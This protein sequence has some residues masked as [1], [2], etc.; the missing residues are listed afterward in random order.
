MSSK[1]RRPAASVRKRRYV[2]GPHLR[3]PRAGWYYAYLSKDEPRVALHT[4]NPAEAARIFG[5]LLDGRR[6]RGVGG[7]AEEVPLAEI[8][9]RYLSAP[10]G[11]TARTVRACEERALAFVKWMDQHNVSLASQITAELRDQ[12]VT[13]RM[14][15]AGRKGTGVKRSTVNRDIVVARKMLK[16]AAHAERL[17]CAR[18]APME[19]IQP[20]REPR[21]LPPPIIPSPR[22]VALAIAALERLGDHGGALYLASVLSTGM[23]IDETRNV[24]LG[25]VHANGVQLG[26]VNGA[27]A[28]DEWTVKGFAARNI[29]LAPASVD[30]FTR[31]IAWRNGDAESARAALS[32]TWAGDVCDRAAKAAG[33][34]RFRSH[35]LRRTFATECYR[36]DIPLVTIQLWMGHKDPE[37]TKRYLGH[38]RDDAGAVAP[39][40]AALSIFTAKLG[41]VVPMRRAKAT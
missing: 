1:D 6:P 13:H 3:A 34:A 37:T 29:P 40:P 14:T 39:T 5:E 30:V 20:P 4:R 15:T 35:D 24:E 17:L 31:F 10:H 32:D 38:Y 27:T 33:I 12:W 23:R 19:S 8:A 16:W 25:M 28:A 41:D 36:A 22:E 7:P 26:P 9:K 21:R 2:P 11:W 18:C